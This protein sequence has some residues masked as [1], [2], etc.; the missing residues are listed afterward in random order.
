MLGMVISRSNVCYAKRGVAFGIGTDSSKQTQTSVCR[1]TLFE[2][3]DCVFKM[4]NTEKI[5]EGK[6]RNK[7]I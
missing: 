7:Y 2:K 4:Y 5:E 1:I 3:H 6:T